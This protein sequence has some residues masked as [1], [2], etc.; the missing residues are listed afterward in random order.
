MEKGIETGKEQK[1][2]QIVKE[3]IKRKTS[4]EFIIDMTK[5]DKKQLEKIKKEMQVC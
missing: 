3:M 5:I 2:I 1:M 4:D